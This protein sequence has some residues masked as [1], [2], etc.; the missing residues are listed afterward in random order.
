MRDRIIA[1]AK[2]YKVPVMYP[3]TIYT[4]S[5]GLMSYTADPSETDKRS[6]EG[7]PAFCM[8]PIIHS[9]QYIFAIL[10]ATNGLCSM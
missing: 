8:I 9:V 2:N 6:R 5:G 4:R 1:L 3:S 10:D 7:V